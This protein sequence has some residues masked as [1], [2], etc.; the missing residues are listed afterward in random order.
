MKPPPRDWPR[1]SSAVFYEDPAAAVEWLCKAFGFQCRVKIEGGEG[2]IVH[3]EL[4][5][6]GGVIIVAGTKLRP[7]R[8]PHSPRQLDGANTQ[9][10]FVYV[11]DVDVHCAHARRA[12][13]VI[14]QEPET[15]DYGEGYWVDRGYQAR[16]PEGHHWW[17]AQRVR[18]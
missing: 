11:D 6:D 7:E 1:I 16:D 12:G 13:A 2:V 5:F 10:L 8:Y 17:F 4:T 18:G 3:T 15:T 14:S 9:A